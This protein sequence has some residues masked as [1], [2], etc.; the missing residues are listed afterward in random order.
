MSQFNPKKLN[1]EA[2]HAGQRYP[3]TRSAFLPSD[4]NEIIESLYGISLGVENSA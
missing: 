3:D 1:I 4:V 2:I